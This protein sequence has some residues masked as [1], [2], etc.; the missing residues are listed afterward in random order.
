M[1]DSHSDALPESRIIGTE[2][3]PVR[4]LDDVLADDLA[5]S[6]SV[7]LKIDTQGFEAQV[8]RGSDGILDRV[9]LVELELSVLGVDRSPSLHRRF[10]AKPIHRGRHGRVGHP[11]NYGSGVSKTALLFTITTALAASS[12]GLGVFALFFGSDYLPERIGGMLVAASLVAVTLLAWRL[13]RI[14]RELRSILLGQDGSGEGLVHFVQQ[15]QSQ[16]EAV[17]DKTDQLL[18]YTGLQITDISARIE[19]IQETTQ[20]LEQQAA[21]EHASVETHLQAAKTLQETLEGLGQ[22]LGAEEHRSALMERRQSALITMVRDGLRNGR[23]V[24]LEVTDDALIVTRE[25]VRRDGRESGVG[26]GE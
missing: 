25:T 24:G 16:I 20:I 17:N 6:R 22:R 23:L 19:A 5:A 2:T 12:L 10:P 4:R 21:D 9:S 26:S 11:A 3:V 18:Q 1:L 8:L 15:S 7:F 14:E 13:W